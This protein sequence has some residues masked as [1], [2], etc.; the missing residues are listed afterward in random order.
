MSGAVRGDCASPMPFTLPAPAATAAAAATAATTTAGLTTASTTG[1]ATGPTTTAGAI[2]SATTT[3]FSAPLRG[4]L[5]AGLAAIAILACG[6][7]V[8]HPLERT[9][10]AASA[11][12]G[13]RGRAGFAPPGCRLSLARF[14]VPSSG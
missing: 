1:R 9:S 3:T 12:V 11:L 8:A 14:V 10:L 6:V 2:G 13:A 7:A 5:P 4:A